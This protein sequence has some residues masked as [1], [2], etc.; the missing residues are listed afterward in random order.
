[1]LYFE[2]RSKAQGSDD[3]ESKL[4]I[5][6]SFQTIEQFWTLFSWLKRPNVS[7]I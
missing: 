3:F 2:I 5:I 6:G 7:I 1:M 4:K